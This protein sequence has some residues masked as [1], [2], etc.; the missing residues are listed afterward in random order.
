MFSQLK[1]LAKNYAGRRNGSNH[2]M[3]KKKSSTT[4]QRYAANTNVDFGSLAR[5]EAIARDMWWLVLI[6][7]IALLGFGFVAILWPGSTLITMAAIFAVYVL[8]TGVVDVVVGVRS[9]GHDSMWFL[10]LVLGAVEV[11]LGVYIL[12][13]GPLLTLSVFILMIGLLF[14]FQG[15][16]QIVSSFMGPR[17]LGSRFWLIFCGV[18]GLIAGGIVLRHPISSGLTFTWVLGFYGIFV[19]AMAIAASFGIRGQQRTLKT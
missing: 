2:K 15:I 13:R 14:F 3:A 6:Q 11:G 5:D 8:I 12:R 10:R 19:G 17:D 16:V 7:G 9:V 1:R 4:K 18:M